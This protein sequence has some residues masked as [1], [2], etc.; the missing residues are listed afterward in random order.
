MTRS[1]RFK[2]EA[3]Q[4]L[5]EAHAYSE[6]QRPGLGNEMLLCVEAAV[7]SV[8]RHPKAHAAVES[9]IRRALVRRFPH[10][11]FFLIEPSEIVVIGVFHAARDP[12]AWRARR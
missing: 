5:D 11:V 1:V 10:G 3:E 4:D 2:P 9:D 7:E 12:R 8:R 6:G